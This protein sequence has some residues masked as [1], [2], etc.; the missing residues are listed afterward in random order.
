MNILGAEAWPIGFD[1]EAANCIWLKSIHERLAGPPERVLTLPE[2][3][4]GLVPNVGYKW[5]AK[6]AVEQE[7]RDLRQ[8]VSRIRH[9]SVGALSE[10]ILDAWAPGQVSPKLLKYLDRAAPFLQL[11]SEQRRERGLLRE[12]EPELARVPIDWTAAVT[13]TRV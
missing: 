13:A 11:R 8:S 6:P 3:T 7:A 2:S 1:Q 9:K 10:Q 4:C 12:V 5:R